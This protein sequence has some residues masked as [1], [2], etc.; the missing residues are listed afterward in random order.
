MKGSWSESQKECVVDITID[1]LQ[2][3]GNKMLV[4][5]LAKDDAPIEMPF[6]KQQDAIIECCYNPLIFRVILAAGNLYLLSDLFSLSVLS[7]R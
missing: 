4:G 6:L 2:T 5:N 3:K 7:L 1:K